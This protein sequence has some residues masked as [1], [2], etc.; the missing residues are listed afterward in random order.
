MTLKTENSVS[1]TSIQLHQQRSLLHKAE[2]WDEN[3]TIL[4]RR[5]D[6]QSLESKTQIFSKR[7]DSGLGERG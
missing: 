4:L 1:P 3:I 2:K 5:E 7:R 6:I